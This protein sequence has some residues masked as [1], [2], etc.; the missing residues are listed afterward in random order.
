VLFGSSALPEARELVLLVLVGTRPDDPI[1]ALLEIAAE[2]SVP[3]AQH[4]VA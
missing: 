2:R 3:K 4:W 1:F